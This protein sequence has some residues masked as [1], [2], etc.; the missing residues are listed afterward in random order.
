MQNLYDLI[1]DAHNEFSLDYILEDMSVDEEEDNWDEQVELYTI[2]F[3][4]YKQEWRFKWQHQRMT[5]DHHVK[6]LLHEC[7][8]DRQYHMSFDA[9]NILL[10]LLHP[11]I[12]C[13]I[14]KSLS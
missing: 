9:F 13:N 1:S 10:E 11:A 5:W 2:L 8:F 4:E 7:H 3:E 12:T 14:I 6:K